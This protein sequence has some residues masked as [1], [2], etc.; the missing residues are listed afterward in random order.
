MINADEN[1]ESRLVKIWFLPSKNAAPRFCYPANL[2]RER[3]S[4]T[5][6]KKGDNVT[7]L[8]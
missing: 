5:S 8:V 2:Y 7:C 4:L 3:G 6:S 1:F